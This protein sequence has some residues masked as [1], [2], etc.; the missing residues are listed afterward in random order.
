[1]YLL[2]WLYIYE[3]PLGMF[4]GHRCLEFPERLVCF[5]N[6]MPSA[7][8]LTYINV[9]MNSIVNSQCQQQSPWHL[10]RI[11]QPGSFN[12][13][14]YN[15]YPAN[16]SKIEF[17]VL[18]TWMDVNHPELEKRVDRWKSFVSHDPGQYPAHATHCAGLIGSKSFGTARQSKI[19]SVQV[20]DDTGSGDYATMIEAINYVYLRLKNS[21]TKKFIVSMSIGG[22]RSEALNR[23]LEVLLR[24]SPV[25]VAAGNS[26]ED[27]CNVSPASSLAFTVAASGPFNKFATFSNFGKCVDAIA[28]GESILSLCPNEKTCWMGGTS[29]ATPLTAG[30]LAHYWLEK[31]QF[32]AQQL[33][34]YFS[35]S[36]ARNIVSGVPPASNTPN[37]FLQKIT[38]PCFYEEFINQQEDYAPYYSGCPF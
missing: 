38:A 22:P 26:A 23:A 11:Q 24:L 16:T 2:K 28:P 12:Y 20:L 25:V 13:F 21:P 9:S 17:V 5:G 19:H 35:H 37:R 8:D 14:N 31:P 6:T 32:N 36:L 18:D 29:M 30:L 1:M 4:Y 33:L 15:P 27:A 34:S 7:F 3:V 10:S